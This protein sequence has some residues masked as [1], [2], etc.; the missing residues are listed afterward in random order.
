M[1]RVGF[2][3]VTP[4]ARGPAAPTQTAPL[5]SPPAPGAPRP[6]WGGRK[7]FPEAS[8]HISC[9]R[10]DRA[11][12]AAGQSSATDSFLA[13]VPRL[14]F[15]SLGSE[16]KLPRGK[17][18][19]AREGLLGESSLYLLSHGDG[20]RVPSRP[21]PGHARLPAAKGFP[22]EFQLQSGSA[23]SSGVSR[24]SPRRAAHEGR[25][26][27]DLPASAARR[28]PSGVLLGRMS[29][30][31]SAGNGNGNQG[32]VGPSVARG[33]RGVL[34][35]ADSASLGLWEKNV[36]AVGTNAFR[37]ERKPRESA[38]AAESPETER[39]KEG[40]STRISRGVLEASVLHALCIVCREHLSAGP[41]PAQ[42]RVPVP[43]G[44]TGPSRG[45]ERAFTGVRRP[46]RNARWASLSTFAPLGY[47][48]T[49]F[50]HDDHLDRRQGRK[51]GER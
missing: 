16:S 45:A 9:T 10:P 8:T 50:P 28:A 30:L 42:D 26:S 33:S 25:G 17:S 23:G 22:E 4:P 41:E 46:Q 40:N 29:K 36:F 44:T 19:T 35:A 1:K 48:F 39:R 14:V 21:A 49:F 31:S 13:T 11:G 34:P 51:P 12:R 27:C 43:S 37:S 5:P 32:G 24:G 2:R 7:R 18:H 6:G 15:K 3:R 47:L 20:A 38:E